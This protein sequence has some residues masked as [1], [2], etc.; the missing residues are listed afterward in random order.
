VLLG[1]PLGSLVGDALGEN[2]GATEV[3]AKVVGALL[4][5]TVGSVGAI[6]GVLV[7]EVGEFEGCA[8]PTTEILH[9]PDDKHDRAVGS[10]TRLPGHGE[11]GEQAEFILSG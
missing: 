10:Q 9:V 11:L 4:G 5:A 6:V 8:L 2:E 7:G 1:L 3:G